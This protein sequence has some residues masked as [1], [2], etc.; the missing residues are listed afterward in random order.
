MGEELI[1]AKTAIKE[2]KLFDS[3]KQIATRIIFNRAFDR[4]LT[5]L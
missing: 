1:P 5:F 3:L 2:L 4:S